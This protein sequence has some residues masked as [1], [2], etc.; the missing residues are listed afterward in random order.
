MTPLA[1][2]ATQINELFKSLT[3]SGF[4]EQQALYMLGV[5]MASGQRSSDE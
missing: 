3:A 1:E 2:A 4:T 5:F